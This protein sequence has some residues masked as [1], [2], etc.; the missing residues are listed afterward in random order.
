MA[1]HEEEKKVA[2]VVKD[3]RRFDASGNARTSEDTRPE[4][5]PAAG[6]AAVPIV[7][8]MAV[9]DAIVALHRAG[10]QVRVV[11]RAVGLARTTLPLGGDT[12]PR[13][14]VVTLYADSI[15]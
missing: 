12:L 6:T 4:P 1:E 2:F 8:G 9:R 10:Y 13:A 15:P 3:R 14:R 11:G 5:A 7:Q